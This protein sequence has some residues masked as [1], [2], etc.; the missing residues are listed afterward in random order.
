MQFSAISK[1]VVKERER[2]HLLIALIVR[3][4]GEIICETESEGKGDF[5]FL[6]SGLGWRTPGGELEKHKMRYSGSAR[7]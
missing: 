7:P 6:V 1:S 4:E 5:L 2:H 3:Q